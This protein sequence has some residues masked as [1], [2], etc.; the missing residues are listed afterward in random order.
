MTVDLSVD[1]GAQWIIESCQDKSCH[2]ES[3]ALRTKK[4][5]GESSPTALCFDQRGNVDEGFSP[6]GCHVKP[7]WLP[8]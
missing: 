1:D 2:G 4:A 3:F 8:C 5:A 6:F 7:V